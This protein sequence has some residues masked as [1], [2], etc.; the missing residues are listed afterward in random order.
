MKIPEVGL[1]VEKTTNQMDITCSIC[2]DD[3]SDCQLKKCGHNFHILCIL[4]WKIEC[5]KCPLC[6]NDEIDVVP[7]ANKFG[8]INTIEKLCNDYDNTI[9]S[10]IKNETIVKKYDRELEQLKKNIDELNQM[11]D[12]TYIG[13]I[14]Y[15]RKRDND[16]KNIDELTKIKAFLYN[17]NKKYSE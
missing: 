13:V 6:K 4:K 2:L 12:T 11:L 14:T 5:D 3:D 7:H 9:K 1:K 16:L 15:M 10:Y 8:I 17:I